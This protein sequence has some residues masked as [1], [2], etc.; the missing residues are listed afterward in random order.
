M[1]SEQHGQTRLQL[2]TDHVVFESLQRT[3]QLRRNKMETE[4]LAEAIEI[5]ISDDSISMASFQRP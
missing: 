3:E 2:I 4:I 5:I 1:Q